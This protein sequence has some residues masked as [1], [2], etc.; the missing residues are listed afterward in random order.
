MREAWDEDVRA[1]VERAVERDGFRLVIVD[2]ITF[3]GRQSE[4]ARDALP[5]MHA[6]HRLKRRHGLSMLVLAHTP[7][8]DES[9]PIT[10]ND[11]AGSRHLANFAD[12]VFALG[13]SSREPD[14]RY[15]KQLKVRSAELERHAENVAV[16]RV[17]KRGPM[18]GLWHEDDGEEREHLQERTQADHVEL[19]AEIVALAASE[20]SLSHRE[21]ARRL[22]TNHKKVGRALSRVEQDGGTPGTGGTGVPG[23]PPVPPGGDGWI[24][25]P[26][27]SAPNASDDPWSTEDPR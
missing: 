1:A 15:V 16:C 22:G 6:L 11:L 8:R 9:R 27:A 5:L 3:L 10:L 14:V 21:I 13:R 20:P 7:K 18:L 2:N 24:G 26:P 12:G 23:V 4:K 17:E 25:P 19:D